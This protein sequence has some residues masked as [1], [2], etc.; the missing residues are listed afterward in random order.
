MTFEKLSTLLPSILSA[1]VM[2]CDLIGFRPTWHDQ[3]LFIQLNGQIG[4]LKQ[5]IRS[6]NEN[7]SSYCTNIESLAKSTSI[8]MKLFF[9]MI[10][11]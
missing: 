6:K 11:K 5:T 3:P 1:M 8:M 2:C 9:L 10:M 7:H 4:A